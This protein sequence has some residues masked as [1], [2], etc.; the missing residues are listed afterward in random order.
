MVELRRVGVVED[1]ERQTDV[2]RCRPEPGGDEGLEER[3]IFPVDVE[4]AEGD[5]FVAE[6][7][8]AVGPRS[9]RAISRIAGSRSFAPSPQMTCSVRPGAEELGSADARP[10]EAHLCQ[11]RGAEHLEVVLVR[12]IDEG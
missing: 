6:L 12:L 9:H 11:R 3:I 8:L 4:V 1:R 10:G 7:V 5:E 2:S